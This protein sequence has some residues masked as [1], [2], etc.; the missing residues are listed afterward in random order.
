MC[1]TAC[2]QGPTLA[3]I[4]GRTADNPR[5]LKEVP[6]AIVAPR[7]RPR[8]SAAHRPHHLHHPDTAAATAALPPR[9]PRAAPRRAAPHRAARLHCR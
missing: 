1:I 6:P 5:L 9:R 4:S 8:A 3:L 2:W 7:C